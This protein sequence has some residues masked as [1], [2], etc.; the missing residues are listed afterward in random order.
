[1]VKIRC[2]D[3]FGKPHEFNESEYIDRESVHGILLLKDSV[4]LVEDRHSKFWDF[5]GGGVEKDEN[6]I[7]AL[8]REFIE[9]TGITDISIGVEVEN[10][11]DYFFNVHSQEPWRSHRHF[12]LVKAN[13]HELKTQTNAEDICEAKLIP[14]AELLGYK[15]KDKA[16]ELIINLTK[17]A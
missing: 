6:L 17:Q 13:I 11:I 14:V 12:Y 9:E 16:K 4:L 10:S 2:T 15:I 8:K 3:N 7:Q 5:P 1:M